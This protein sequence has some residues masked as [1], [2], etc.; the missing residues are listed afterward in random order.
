M[1]T[2]EERNTYTQIDAP[3]VR[4]ICDQVLN[5]DLS[6]QET[7]CGL[8]VL[9]LKTSSNSPKWTYSEMRE[10]NSR[11]S[12][13]SKTMRSL[14]Q[15]KL[16]SVRSTKDKKSDPIQDFNK[17]TQGMTFAQKIEYLNM[18]DAERG[19][20][21]EKVLIQERKEKKQ[22]EKEQAK[23]RK[24]K[25]P[26]KYKKQKVYVFVLNMRGQ[27]LMPTSPRKARLLLKN[28]KAKVVKRC[29]YTIQ[30]NYPT[31][32]NKQP[33]KLGIDSG[34]EHV[35]LSATTDKKELFSADVT[36]RTDI[37]DKMTEKAMYRK[38][39]RNRNTRYREPRWLNRGIPEGWL[40]PSI[41]HKLDSHVRL[42]DNIKQI[43]PI[44]NNDITI[45]VATFDT[46][47]MNNPEISGIEYQQGT[48]QG[49]EVR[50][51]LLEKWGRKCAYCKVENVPFEIEHI[52][53]PSRFGLCGNNRISNLTIACHDCNQKKCNMTAA[54]FG[55]PEVQVLAQKSLKDAAFM[56]IVRWRLV[57]SIPEC[58]HTY[59]YVTKYNRIRLGLEKSHIN[60]AFVIANRN[61][62]LN[63]ERCKSFEV[64]QIRR[65][66]RS[67]QLNRKGFEPSIRKKR[68]KYSPGD[69]VLFKD[70]NTEAHV[71][72]VK[73]V[74]NYGEWI[75]LVNPIP[76]EKDISTNIKNVRIVKYGKGFRFSYPDF[77]INPDIV[78]VKTKEI[79][80]TIIEDIEKHETTIQ[81]DVFG[82]EVIRQ[83]K[84]IEKKQ[85]IK[86]IKTQ[87]DLFGKI[88]KQNKSKKITKKKTETVESIDSTTQVGIDNA[89]N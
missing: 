81:Y 37:P 48:L 57:N 65:N 14:Y 46:Q 66:N 58:H 32:E 28:K 30:L 24:P 3:Q 6:G 10:Q 27:P 47:K 73:G 79:E 5:K 36:L 74:F 83:S 13:K 25:E 19:K 53:P 7:G 88:I 35:G 52:I 56:N 67:L 16:K 59:G 70:N 38:G 85:V 62:Q 29:P 20:I 21:I 78:N 51:Y 55:H 49:Y 89:W 12:V 54:E 77:S 68:Y 4:R 39:R 34:Y 69:L 33:I 76:G 22:K 44:N 40:A 80:K 75:R 18:S 8:S 42:I 9:D 82:E 61:N 11:V 31:G 23:D 87:Y 60:D 86:N 63:Q 17:Y 1:Q 64:K 15:L 26:T 45:E 72:V 43:L 71:C 41:Q 50:E 2:L 84:K